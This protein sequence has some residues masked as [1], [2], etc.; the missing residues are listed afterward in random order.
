[1][2]VIED[3]RGRHSPLVERVKRIL[4]KPSDEWPVIDAEPA[5]I[6]GIYR[7]HVLPLAAIPAVAGLI[8]GLLFGH[9]AFGITYRPSVAGSITTALIQYGMALVGIYVLALVIDA[10]APNFGA[11]RNRVQAFKVA[12]YA[13]TASWVA[14]IFALL[15][16]ITFLSILGLY[17]LYLLFLGLPRLMR[18][19][20][21]KA[22]S[23][24]VLVIV[25][26]VLVTIAAGLLVA[27]IVGLLSFGGAT[28]ASDTGTVS[29]TLNVPGVGSV[30]I[31]AMEAASRKLE[32]QSKAG[33]TAAVEPAA[34]QAML[35]LALPGGF[36]RSEVSN[37]S[38]GAGGIGGSQAEARYRSGEADIRLEAR[39]QTDSPNTPV[40]RDQQAAIEVAFR[41]RF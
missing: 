8:G 3:G 28:T 30:D 34:L 31:G 23:Y 9:S 38:A 15:P 12:A 37:A 35:P 24:T 32:A 13:A 39:F 21:D 36:A 16:P 25:V 17:S 19:P 18:A 22:V 7:E 11:T 33:A 29:G 20:Q 2:N 1:M 4:L 41:Q 26:S 5:T 6:G 10:L 27:P 14:G 40:Y